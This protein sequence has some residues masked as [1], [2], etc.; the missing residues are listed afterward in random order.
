M[1]QKVVTSDAAF[2]PAITCTSEG[3]E[4]IRQHGNIVAVRVD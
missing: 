2:S 4:D 3:D 1:L